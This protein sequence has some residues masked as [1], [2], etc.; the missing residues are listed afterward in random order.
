MTRS[1]FQRKYGS[2]DNGVNPP[3]GFATRLQAQA[4]ANKYNHNPDKAGGVQAPGAAPGINAPLPHALSN[5]LA[6]LAAIG[7]F[8]NRLTQPNTWLRVG[9][10]AAGGLLVYLGLSAAMK[11]T[12]GEQAVK[13]V[14]KPIKAGIDLAP[15]VRG[16]KIARSAKKRVARERKVT[17][18]AKELRAAERAKKANA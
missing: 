3:N 12:M 2:P 17:E 11:G 13:T 7:D 9:E 15:P 10:F 5:P 16:A 8:F 14:T 1:A 6:G 4:A 18:K